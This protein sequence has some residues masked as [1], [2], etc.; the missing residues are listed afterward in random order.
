MDHIGGGSGEEKDP[1]VTLFL[2]IALQ[3]LQAVCKT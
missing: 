2:Q 1:R 3:D